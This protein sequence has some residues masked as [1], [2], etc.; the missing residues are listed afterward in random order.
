MK[1]RE[2]GSVD[3]RADS[4]EILG[5]IQIG[6]A[7]NGQSHLVQYFGAETIFFGFFRC[8]VTAAVQFYDKPSLCAVKIHDIVADGLLSLKANGVLAQKII[9]QLS[10]PRS[11]VSAQIFGKRNVSA[12]ILLHIGSLP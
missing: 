1:G 10:F 5:D 8:I 4:A 6:K 7:K 12:V 2:N 11:H 9:P 3:V